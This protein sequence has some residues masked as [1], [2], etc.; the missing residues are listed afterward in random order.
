M[1]RVF[2]LSAVSA[3]TS[4]NVL[5]GLRRKYFWKAQVKCKYKQVL[6]GA[7]RRCECMYRGHFQI[8]FL[9]VLVL[10]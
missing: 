7:N 1:K 5:R 2:L 8:F 4:R 10:H 6:V 3:Q 9:V